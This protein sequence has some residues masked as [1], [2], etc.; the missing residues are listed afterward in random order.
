ML[1]NFVH[2]APTSKQH[3]RQENLKQNFLKKYTTFLCDFYHLSHSFL[4]DF[5]S[6]KIH[7]CH[8]NENYSNIARTRPEKEKETFLKNKTRHATSS[9]FAPKL[10]HGSKIPGVMNGHMSGAG[11]KRNNPQTVTAVPERLGGGN[12]YLTGTPCDLAASGIRMY[13]FNCTLTGLYAITS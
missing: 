12:I 10:V 8:K 3:M 13:S 6:L 4:F 11:M 2:V 7:L 1:G 5:S 9:Q